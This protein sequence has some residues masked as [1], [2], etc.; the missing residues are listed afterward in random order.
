MSIIEGDEIEEAPFFSSTGDWFLNGCR[1]AKI[2]FVLMTKS[3]PRKVLIAQ[4]FSFASNF[5]EFYTDKAAFTFEPGLRFTIGEMLGRDTNNREH[6]VELTYLGSFNWVTRAKFESASPGQIG[7]L[8]G[9]NAITIGGFNGASIQDY[10]YRA[11]LNSVAINYKIQNRPARDR[12][13][14]Q[15]DGSWEQQA[16]PS[17][18]PA[19]YIGLR[20]ISADERFLYSSFG[21][22]TAQFMGTYRTTTDNNM[23]GIHLGGEYYEDYENWSFG[24]KGGLGGLVNFADRTS[25]VHDVSNFVTTV[26]TEEVDEVNLVFLGELSLDSRL[27]L[28][29]QSSFHL[30]FDML[31]LNGLALAPENM[32][33]NATTFPR[34]NTGGDAL[35]QSLSAG[36]DFVW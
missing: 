20:G 9:P 23:V 11:D 13:V 17:S 12:L 15:P 36:F 2:D 3:P 29:P 33:L 31:Y 8:L 24:V 25:Q 30:S 7:S 19:Y 21:V 16:S 6:M 1:Y 18:M 4:D 28:T 10:F 34:L 22:N 32:E 27:K 35:Y 14:M 5:P 26:R